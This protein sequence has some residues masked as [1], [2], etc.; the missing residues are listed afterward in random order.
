[1]GVPVLQLPTDLMALQELICTIKPTSVIE[2]GTAFGGTALFFASMLHLLGGK[3]KVITIDIALKNINKENITKSNLRDSII[4]LEGDSTD[5]QMVNWAQRFIAFDSSPGPVMVV[6]DSNHTHDHVL[7]ELKLYSKLVTV[8][9]YLI[10]MDTTIEWLDK[11]YIGDR[12]WG[13][14]NSPWSAVQEFMKDNN[15]FEVDTEIEDRILLTSAVG[16]WLRR[17]K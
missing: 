9:S 4:F 17:V 11:K 16:G 10:V 5:K 7:K 15:E 8:G 14:G 6:L 1:M 2:T 3:R 12:P 13:K